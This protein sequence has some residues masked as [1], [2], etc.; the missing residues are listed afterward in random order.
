[1]K[2]IKLFE[3]FTQEGQVTAYVGETPVKLKIASTE[4]EK[5]RGHNRP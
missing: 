2:F 1:M 5:R 4:Q 3:E